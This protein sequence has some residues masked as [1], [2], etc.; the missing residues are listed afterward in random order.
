MLMTGTQTAMSLEWIIRYLL[1]F[2]RAMPGCCEFHHAA[3]AGFSGEEVDQA[4]KRKID[5]DQSS[6]I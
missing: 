3:E 1:D 6:D 5:Q 4:K 2:A